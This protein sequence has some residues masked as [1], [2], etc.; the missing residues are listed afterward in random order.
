MTSGGRLLCLLGALI[1]VG[2]AGATAH[3]ATP[4]QL[5]AANP[6]GAV[7]LSDEQTESRWGYST[8]RARIYSRPSGRARTITRLHLLTEDGFPEIYLALARWVDPQN[9]VW[10]KIRVPMRP[11]GRTG[12]VRDDALTSLTVV[13]KMLDVD[14]KKLRA[15]LYDGGKV[16]FTA[17]IGIGKPSTPTPSGHFWIRE[18]FPVHNVPLYGT[19]AIG[20]AAYA[21]TLSDWPGGG[22]VGL[23]GTNQPGLIPGR[24]SHGCIRLRNADIARLYRLAP[25]GTPIHIH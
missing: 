10:L 16:V 7:R 25:R 13:R 8:R 14:K 2:A 22:V 23:H 21:P 11:N 20:T 3:A 6:E 9:N 12:W 18:K 1:V 24:P 19:H 4:P 15:T 5:P 17:R